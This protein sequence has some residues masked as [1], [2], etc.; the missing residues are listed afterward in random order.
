[1]DFCVGSLRGNP[2]GGLT[3]AYTPSPP[4]S[5]ELTTFMLWAGTHTHHIHQERTDLTHLEY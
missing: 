3:S 1:M 2:G 5:D 4:Q